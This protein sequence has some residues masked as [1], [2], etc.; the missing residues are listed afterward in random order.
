MSISSKNTFTATFRLV[1][2]Q[3]VGHSSLATLTHEINHRIH[4]PTFSLDSPNQPQALDSL[5]VTVPYVIFWDERRE[6]NQTL[7]PNGRFYP[8]DTHLTVSDAELDG[9]QL[10]RRVNFSLISRNPAMPQETHILSVLCFAALNVLGFFPLMLIV[11][12]Q[13]QVAHECSRHRK[14]RWEDRGCGLW[15]SPLLEKQSFS[16]NHL[17][18]LPLVSTDRPREW[19][20]R[21]ETRVLP[22]AGNIAVPNRTGVLLARKKET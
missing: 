7:S 11:S 8:L 9:Q 19:Q 12:C 5:I 17:S 6:Q 14:S 20:G 4:H 10:K 2:D 22:R 18:S 15:P 16:R 3:I 13:L 21:L 1:F